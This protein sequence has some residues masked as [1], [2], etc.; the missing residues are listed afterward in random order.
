MGRKAT[1]KW[2]RRDPENWRAMRR[3]LRYA[4]K[5]RGGDFDVLS[6][7]NEGQLYE[8]MELP[9]LV[10]CCGVRVLKLL[11]GLRFRLLAKARQ[12]GMPQRFSVRGIICEWFMRRAGIPTPDP[13]L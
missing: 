6:R 4:R 8:R 5:G 2:Q 11:L 7:Q 3:L 13:I 12:T 10:R 1:I 9:F